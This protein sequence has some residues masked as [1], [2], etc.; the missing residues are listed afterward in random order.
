MIGEKIV[1]QDSRAVAQVVRTAA[2]SVD[3]VKLNTNNFTVGE[4]VE[5]KE[6]SRSAIIQE[7]NPGSYVDKTPN[8]RLDKG[9]R[10]QYC[11]YSRIVRRDG[12]AIPSRQLLVI[13][14][15]YAVGS[16]NTGDIFT[17]NSYSQDRYRS[18]LPVLPNGLRASDFLDFRPRVSAF[19]TS[20]N[21]SPFAFS[22]REY[23]YNYKYVVSPE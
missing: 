2:N 5:F 8:Y 12:A 16:N 6:S 23:E 19:D 11:D 4:L 10:H 7:V 18:D 14:D 20:T 13:F 22:S 1:G 15:S 3:Y 9:H 21:A 17:V